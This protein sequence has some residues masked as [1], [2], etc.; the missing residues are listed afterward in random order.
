MGQALWITIRLAAFLAVVA[1]A[2][3]LCIKNQNKKHRG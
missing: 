2:I 1:T 3:V